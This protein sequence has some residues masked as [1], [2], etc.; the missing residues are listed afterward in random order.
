MTKVLPGAF[1]NQKISSDDIA[2][3]LPGIYGSDG[4]PP[5]AINMYLAVTISGIPSAPFNYI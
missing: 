2:C 1:F 5:V 3:Y 4:L